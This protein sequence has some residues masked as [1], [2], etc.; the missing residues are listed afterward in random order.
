MKSENCR[1]D[2]SENGVA[3]LTL[4][5]T[6]Q[7]NALSTSFI[8]EI[9]SAIDSII[10][11]DKIRVLIITGSGKAFISGA[12]ISEM[13][14]FT[15]EDALRFAL[16]GNTLFRKIE[17]LKIPVI[18]AINGY[19]LGGGCEFALA[20]DIRIA[21]QKAKFGQPEVGLGITPGFS[22]T[23]RLPK[24]VGIAK[25]KELIFTGKII[26]AEEALAIGLINL[27]TTEDELIIKA[28]ELAN[29]IASKAPIAVKNSKSAINMSQE[30][31]PDSGSEIEAELFSECFNSEDQKFGMKGFLN[32]E[33]VVYK[34]R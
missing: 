15:K 27:I 14:D 1:V 13:S 33:K 21:S 17:T 29:T 8:K 3:T 12:D 16:Q 7:L 4:D 24:V 6:L 10:K 9:D 30:S 31:D 11:D 5:N 28:N 32:K 34:N 2:L 23:Q 26:D 25:A 22:G 19:A 20:C 18:A